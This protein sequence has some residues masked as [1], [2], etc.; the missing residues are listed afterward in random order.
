MFARGGRLVVPAVAALCTAG[1]AACAPTVAVPAPAPPAGP[2]SFTLVATGDVLVHQERSLVA[3]AQAAGRVR[4]TAFDFSPVLADVAPTIRGADVAVCHLEA[5]VAPPAGPFTGYPS[6]SAQP[7]ILDALAGAGYD[8]CSTASNHSLDAGPA[9]V[10]R[11]LEALDAR[12]LR[13][14]GT[15]RDAA[16]AATPTVL[17]VGGVRVGHVATT[18]G[19]NGYPVPAGTP[20]LVDTFAPSR[21]PDVRGVLADAAAARKAGADVVVASVHCCT[22]Y[23]DEPTAEQRAVVDRLLDSPDVDLVLGHHAHVVQPFGTRGGKWV[24]YGLG[25]HVADQTTGGRTRDSVIARFTFARGPGGRFAVNR[26]EAVPVTIRPGGTRFA[27]V[28]S[29]PGDPSYSHVTG[30]LRRGSAPEIA[31]G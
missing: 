29:S 5:P 23:V 30:V 24:A 11:T 31:G 1:L 22:E 14:A 26:A 8:T 10:V 12:T 21:T 4:G 3:T 13:H 27:V 18:F 17:D 28:R 15:A 6:F 7:Q 19:L 16:E 25:N 9:G 2:A 20:W